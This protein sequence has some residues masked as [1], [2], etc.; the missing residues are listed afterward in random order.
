MRHFILFLFLIINYNIYPNYRHIKPYK[1]S[2]VIKV[3]SGSYTAVGVNNPYD[4]IHAF[5]RR[6][7]DNFGGYINQK[8]DSA[9]LEIN[10]SGIKADIKSLE[11]YINPY[12]LTVN[13]TANIGESSDGNSYTNI[14]SRGSAGGGPSA[15]EPQ[16]KKM[17]AKHPGKNH[18]LLLDFNINLIM[19]YDSHGIKKSNCNGQINIRQWFYKFY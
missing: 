18:V 2:E 5:N 1:K 16:L 3:V 7:S 15:I 11:I 6:I 4:A 10:N 9:L 12:T 17:F 19:C 14:D 8:I 13:W